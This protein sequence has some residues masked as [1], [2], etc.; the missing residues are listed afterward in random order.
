MLKS[1]IHIHD[2][3][4]LKEPRSSDVDLFFDCKAKFVVVGTDGPL[5]RCQHLKSSYTISDLPYRFEVVS[6]YNE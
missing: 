1:E 2:I 5:L 4:H 6:E 3:V